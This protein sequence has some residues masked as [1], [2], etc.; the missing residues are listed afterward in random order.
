MILTM[1]NQKLLFILIAAL[2]ISFSSNA[3]VDLSGPVPNDPEIRMG[4][5]NNGLTYFIRKN[6]EPKNRASFYIIQNVG[7][8]LENDDQ[9][10]LAHFLEHMAFNG[11]E[12]FPGKG[13]ISGL[14]KHGVKF[15][16][17][18]NA[19]TGYDQTVYQMSDVPVDKPDLIDTCL[20]ILND[21]SDY[22]S[23]TDK[24]IDL[25]RGVILEEWRTYKNAN[26]R[27][28]FDKVIP[29]VLKGSKYAVRDIIGNPDIIKNFSYNTL[30]SFYHDWYR[31]DLQAIAVVGDINPDEVE[32]KI[33]ALFSAI[34]AVKNPATR[35]YDD[36]PYHKETYFVL[37][38]DKEAPQTSV[39]VIVLHKAVSRENKNLKYLRDSY[40]I[41]LMNSMINTRINE[42]LQ[43]PNPPFIGGSVTMDSYM[44]KGYDAFTITA[45]ARQNEE[46][47]ALESIYSEAERARKFGFNKGELERAKARM[48]SNFENTYKQKDKI[49]NDTYAS[50]IQGYF[51]TG[52]P[53]TS[54][55][56]D[57][58]FL[59][60]VIDGISAEEISAKF[61]DL[62]IDENRSIIVQGL[63]GGDIKHLSE[64][65]ALNIISKVKSS[66]LTLYEDKALGKS[67]VKEELKGSS[68]V[69]T[70]SL[71]Q[72]GAVEW[73][74]GNNAKVIY[75]K[76]DYEKDNIILSS[77]SLGGTSL[78]E[79]DMLPS[80]TLLPMIIGTYGIGDYDNVTLQKMLSGKKASAGINLGEVT[81]GVSGSSTP[82]D[83]ET[84]MQLLYM[85]FEKPRFDKESHDAIMS[86]YVAF[87]T[88]MSKDPSKTMQDSLSLFLTNY[89]PRTM[90]FNN[91]MLNNVDFEKIKK[92]YSERF[93]NAA[94]F[95]FFIVGNVSE[96]TVKP[97]VEKYIG[98]IRSN[99]QKENFIDRGVRPPQGKFFRDIQIPLTVPKATVFV[100]HSSSYKYTPYN[101]VCLKVIQGI[102]DLIYLEKIREEQGGT[103]SVSVTVSS[104]LN[105][106]PTAE[107]L[108]MFDCDPARAKDLK[109]IIYNEIDKMVK[110]GPSQVNLDKTVSNMIKNRE[111]AKMHNNY[112]S[113]TLYSYY[114]TGINVNDP[115][116]YEDILKKLTVKDIQKA[117][118][119]I[120]QKANVADIVF[121]PKTE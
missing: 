102:L 7:A 104:Q 29:V 101:N 82:K 103:Y 21:W 88:N 54:A 95:T 50:W 114:Y 112:W 41:M 42:L 65:E 110:E 52:E 10:G 30:R 6:L 58:E 62:M 87:L 31:T 57:F 44:P 76:A 80:A 116:N 111:E 47:L 85:R 32:A 46:A 55:D 8:I 97:M 36:I 20:L 39:S 96:D 118:K 108:I 98:S 81:E 78:Y 2:M 94:D 35:Y 107:D 13:I 12:H 3:Q 51:L 64:Q 75:K 79:V 5:L 18:I 119:M 59:K 100:S 73:T 89:S 66:Q 70:V 71:P 72:F 4:K 99:P 105:P 34:P 117:A 19:F 23:L 120:F 40:M 16:S 61:K 69:K 86:R 77:Y 26:T 22:I 60:Q 121:R 38:T 25:E 90:V 91:A 106:Y 27:M 1:K 17:N 83:F 53:A 15:G 14:E 45:I 43:K 93:N 49:D 24:E 68:I 74:L 33:K 37:A 113:S 63:E 115:K 9:N 28:F 92:I 67:L 84:M 11:T 56:F 48:L 109:A